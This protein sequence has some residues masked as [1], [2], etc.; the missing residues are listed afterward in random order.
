MPRLRLKRPNPRPS[1]PTEPICYETFRTGAIGVL[2]ERGEIFPVDH[3]F[4]LA[5]PAQ[6]R[7]LVRLEEVK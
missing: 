4:V 5:Y 6:F 7:G 1:D 2:V 3:K